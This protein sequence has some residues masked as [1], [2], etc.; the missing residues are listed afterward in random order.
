MFDEIHV[1]F[2]KD[3]YIKALVVT[4]VLW[5]R[6]LEL[7][8]S[9]IVDAVMLEHSVL[10]PF[11]TRHCGPCYRSKLAFGELYEDVCPCYHIPQD[12]KLA[13]VPAMI[14]FSVPVVCLFLQPPEA[15]YVKRLLV[16]A[17]ACFR[18][19]SCECSQSCESC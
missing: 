10:E 19:G 14:P 16:G 7:C 2:D 9:V 8:L 1:S 3:T 17:R 18:N 5:D 4:E 15:S 6:L 12:L 11:F 13:E